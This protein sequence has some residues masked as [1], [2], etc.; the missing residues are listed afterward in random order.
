MIAAVRERK[1]RL[2][3]LVP[4][5]LLDELF[6]HG[7]GFESSYHLVAQLVNQVTHRYPHAKILEIGN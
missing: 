4:C 5:D 3:D 2:E 7:I 1:Q 6:E